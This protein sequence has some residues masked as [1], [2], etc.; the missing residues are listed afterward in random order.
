MKPKVSV[1]IPTVEEE[2]VFKLV[3]QIRTILGRNT[4]IIIVDKSSD[5]YFKSLSINYEQTC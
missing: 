1:V 2:S 3:K 5:A 4:E